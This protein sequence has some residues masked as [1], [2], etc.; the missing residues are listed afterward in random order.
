MKKTLLLISCFSIIFACFAQDELLSK[1]GKRVL[2]Q[3]KDFSLGLDATPFFNYAGNL[4]SSNGNNSLDS[5]GSSVPFTI[6]GKYF[7]KDKLAIR[8][9]FGIGYSNFNDKLTV[10]DVT[11]DDTLDT[12][13]DEVIDRTLNLRIGGGLE[14]RRGSGR[15]Q[16][17]YGPQL[18][19]SYSKSSRIFNYGNSLED[20]AP[21]GNSSS[22]V[23]LSE[24]KNGGVLGVELGGFVGV[25]YFFAPK[26]SISGELSLAVRYENQGESVETFE[27]YERTT[28]III[29]IVEEGTVSNSTEGY[30]LFEVDTRP[31][32]SISLHFYF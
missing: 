27:S 26:I 23:R 17:F 24:I 25:E 20:I 2:P 28:L 22:V 29:P 6:F 7:L 11:S 15:L 31:N 12:K 3:E 32:T 14:F 21:S 16:A 9:S 10:L 18:Q 1:K 8:G 4:F 13:T 5:I 19:L 30:S